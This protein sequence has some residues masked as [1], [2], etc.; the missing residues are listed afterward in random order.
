MFGVQEEFKFDASLY[1][2]LKKHD[3]IFSPQPS[4]V[5]FRMYNI[6]ANSSQDFIL[7]ENKMFFLVLSNPFNAGNL[8]VI[9][10][11]RNSSTCKIS[12][13]T[14]DTTFFDVVPINHT[15]FKVKT[16]GATVTVTMLC[17]GVVSL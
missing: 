1:S 10:T 9:E 5:P 17:I 7:S 16:K 12:C 6:G 3:N 4:E 11:G 2:S 15:S 13:L 14:G 8:Y